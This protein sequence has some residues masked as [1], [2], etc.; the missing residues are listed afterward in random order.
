M[1]ALGPA[2]WPVLLLSAIGLALRLQFAATFDGT[3]RGADYTRHFSG[4]YWMLHHWRA[5]N[6]DPDVNWTVNS[7][8][9]G[10]Y[11]TGAI[12][13]LI[14]HAERAMAFVA[15]GGWVVRQFLLS[16]ILLH[17]LP[18]RRWAILIAMT[19]TAFLPISV[20]TDG[21]TN[22]ETL[23]TS[24]FMI[25]VYW[26]WRMEREARDATGIRLLTAALFGLS[27]GLGMLTKATSGVLPMAL[28]IFVLWRSYVALSAGGTLRDSWQLYLLPAAVSGLVWCLVAGAWVGPNLLNY[29]HPFPHPWDMSPP[30]NAGARWVPGYWDY[31]GNDWA[32][33]RGHWERP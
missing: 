15:V 5:F 10:W 21:T 4:V 16:R 7:Y 3:V 23:H 12:M 19:L 9:P 11:F 2:G 30:P 22:P 32:W 27:A 8:P 31:T 18:H 24:L 20:E 25:A 26:L 13:Y 28:A 17:T 6:F 1:R 14:F 33:N 29:G